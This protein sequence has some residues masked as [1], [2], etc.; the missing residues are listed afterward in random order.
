MKKN[1]IILFGIIFLLSL[2]F[3]NCTKQ[4]LVRAKIVDENDQPIK[5]ALLYFEVYDNDGV[6]DFGFALT[7]EKG[8]APGKNSNPL[9]TRWHPGSHI[10]LAAFS[11]SKK[12]VVLY[13]QLGNITP[14]GMTI[15]LYNLTDSKLHWEP[16]IAKL[17]FPFE[18]GTALNEKAA[19][20]EAKL[21]REAFNKAYQPLL[22]GEVTIFAY[23]KEK[24]EA[25]KK[26]EK[27]SLK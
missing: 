2:F 21:L 12:P 20:P 27:K 5:G 13:D 24:I 17:S 22:N 18:D 6:Y 4:Q 16:R 10:A 7:N 25:I 14:T 26:L 3:Q 23:E 11:E 9:V 1:K 8:E 15:T 19:S